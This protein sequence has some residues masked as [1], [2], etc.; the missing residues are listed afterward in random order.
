MFLKE[1]YKAIGIDLDVHNLIIDYTLPDGARVHVTHQIIANQIKV[2]DQ[3]LIKAVKSSLPD[4][5]RICTIYEIQGDYELDEL[6]KLAMSP[7]LL[8]AVVRCLYADEELVKE[9][10]AEVAAG[11]WH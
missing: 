1:L 5:S 9:Y 6:E 4:G 8:N 7:K 2:T 11:K 3:D 10:V